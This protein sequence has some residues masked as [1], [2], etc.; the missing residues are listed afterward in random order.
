MLSFVFLIRR[1]YGGFCVST[2]TWRGEGLQMMLFRLLLR[3]TT[4]RHECRIAATLRVGGRA[5]RMA[6][7]S[8]GDAF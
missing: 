1:K 2:V 8:I 5:E 6:E 3:D 4:C 7:G